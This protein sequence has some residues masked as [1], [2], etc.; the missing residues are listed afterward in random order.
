MRTIRWTR[1]CNCLAAV[2][3]LGAALAVTATATGAR[4]APSAR[5]A[6]GTFALVPGISPFVYFDTQARGAICEA[7][8]YGYKI[9]YA[10][11]PEY[12]PAAQTKVLNAVLAQK[13]SF[14]MTSPVDSTALRAPIDRF[15]RAGIP[16]LTV[17]AS[18]KNSKGLVTVIQT[19]N[20][21]GG[22]IAGQALGKLMGG[23]GTV[24]VLSLAPGDVTIAARVKGFTDVLKKSYPN[25]EILPT[26]FPGANPSQSQQKMRAL[27]LGHPDLKGVFGTVEVTAEGAAA[28]ID[29]VGKQ[30]QISVAAFDGSPAEVVALRKGSIQFL[31]VSNPYAQ[32]GLAVQFAHL[33]LTGKKSRIPKLVRVKNVGVTK[34]NV[35]TPAVQ[36][37]LYKSGTACKG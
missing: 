32:G 33:Y 26:E 35:D 7:K 6:T 28:A 4:D 21:Q 24:A 19:D 18:L 31:S 8:K 25:I 15:I 20:Y 9:N 36:K 1:A 16:V 13:P 12:T 29:A 17:G 14:L 23:S 3:A 22:Q 30:G 27:M 11:V 37:I 5:A 2:V 34:A 10:T